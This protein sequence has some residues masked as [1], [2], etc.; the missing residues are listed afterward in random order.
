[1]PNWEWYDWCLYGGLATLALLFVVWLLVDII[2]SCVRGEKM[3]LIT[4]LLCWVA[5]TVVWYGGGTMFI[6]FLLK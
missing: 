1:M 2:W 6:Q 3:H 4:I 5:F